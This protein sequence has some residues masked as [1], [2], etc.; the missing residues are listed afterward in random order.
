MN[1]RMN[2]RQIDRPVTRRQA[3]RSCLGRKWLALFLCPGNIWRKQ[4]HQYYIYTDTHAT[5][6]AH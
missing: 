1:R 2:N 5:Y 6:A 3:L 4:T